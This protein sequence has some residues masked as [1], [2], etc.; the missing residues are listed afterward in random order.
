M[1]TKIVYAAV[2]TFAIGTAA[3]AQPPGTLAPKGLIINRNSSG[4]ITSARTIGGNA[5]G[6]STMPSGPSG[7]GFGG[8]GL[9]QGTGGGAPSRSFILGNSV[10]SQNV[11]NAR[12]GTQVRQAT[13]SNCNGRGL[14]WSDLRLKRN[15][16]LIAHLDNGL[17]LYRYS[18]NWSD[19]LYV[20]V[21][22]QDVA[23]LA[24]QAVVRG[25]DGFLQ[26]D[27]R[28]LGLRMQTWDE[29]SASH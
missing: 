4:G 2:A 1:F 23:R 18:Y 20:G 9:F 19:R 12:Q 11:P 16:E 21:M 27:Y 5:P 8:S 3:Q 24:P 15:A 25:V 13:Q 28:R 26:V 7:T 10:N 14:C 29:W 17:D 22:A 6:A